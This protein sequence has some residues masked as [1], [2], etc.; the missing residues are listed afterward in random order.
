MRFVKIYLLLLVFNSM[1]IYGQILPKKPSLSDVRSYNQANLMKVQLGFDKEKV[2]DA[3]GGIQNIQTWYPRN[4]YTWAKP[5]YLVISNPYSRD[6]KRGKDSSNIEILWY[7]TDVKN[8]DEAINKEELTPII[9]E[10][11]VVVGL[12]WGFYT[13]YAKKQEITIDVR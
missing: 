10:K 12:G 8:A 3:M 7:Y 1:N 13:E 5:K 4:P 6:L 9:F 2:L 11:N